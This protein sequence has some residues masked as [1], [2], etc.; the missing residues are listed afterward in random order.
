[1][2]FEIHLANRHRLSKSKPAGNRSERY[3]LP[4]NEA[5]PAPEKYAHGKLGICVLGVIKGV[6]MRRDAIM[7]G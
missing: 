7:K 4:E 3:L 2:D 5:L 1:M 6:K